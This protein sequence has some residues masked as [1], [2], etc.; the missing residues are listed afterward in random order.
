LTVPELRDIIRL[1]RY[2]SN[3]LNQL[4]IRA[5]EFGAVYETDI[6][7]LRD[8]FDSLWDLLNQIL[9]GLSKILSI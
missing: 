2:S 5:H 7:R 3:N 9:V 4:A 6:I 8:S 1:L